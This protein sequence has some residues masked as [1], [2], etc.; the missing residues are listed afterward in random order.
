MGWMKLSDSTPS[1]RYITTT[2][3]STSHSVLDSEA[4]NASA[5]P[6]RRSS[7]PVG[8]PIAARAPSMA[9]TASPSDAPGA[10]LNENVTAG[11]W[12]TWLINRCAGRCSMR[13]MPF[14]GTCLPSGPATCRRAMASGPKA[15]S[16]RASS[17]TRYWLA[18]VKMV[19]IWRWPNA[20]Y[21]ASATA[22]TLMPRRA[23]ATRSIS[24][25]ACRPWSCR[26]LATSARAADCCRWASNRGVHCAS[27]SLSGLVR[28]NWYWVRLIRSSMPSSCTGCRCSVMPGT[29]ATRCCRRAMIACASLLRCAC[30]FS[31]ISN[32]P[33]LSV[34]LLPS[35]PM[36][37]DR[38]AT[39]SS[40]SSAVA[41]ACWRCAMAWNEIDC[42][43]SLMPWIRPASCT[44]KKPLGTHTY[45]AAVSSRVATVA[46]SISGWRCSTQC[47][48][49]SYRATTRS[50]GSPCCADSW[51]SASRRVACPALSRRAHIIGVSVSDTSREIP[52][53]T[54]RVIANS[55]N[56]LPTTSA[57]NSSGISTAISDRV[58]EIRVK[59][60]CRA[61]FSAACIGV[62]PR[63]RWRAMFSS[64]TIASSTTKPVAMVSAIR[65]RLLSENPA[66]SITPKVPTSDSGTAMLGMIVAGR[67]RRNTKV[68]IT[69]S[70]MAISSSCCTPRMEA[71]ID[72]VRSLSTAT[73]TPLGSDA[74]SCGSSARTW[75]TTAIT[76]APGWRWMLISTA[77]V[78]PDHAASWRFSA[79]SS[80][81]ATSPRRSGAPS[82]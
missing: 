4:R 1:T 48:W 17:T 42:G 62:A 76:L 70:A 32:R 82:L 6:C 60:I 71:R 44:G 13:A 37:E 14:N 8:R 45:S 79:P 35:T 24:T 10:R 5:A 50:N 54:A 68:T 77:G 57:M 49:R 63:S 67:L 43:A 9:C 21:S 28:V 7:T 40:S 3:A 38:L 64:I 23:A 59:P 52:I 29:C 55:W 12:P 73:S 51:P 11:N 61:P 58:S 2:A 36:N 65:V 47:S 69:T 66:S 31:S 41:S 16:G 20:S 80:I 18:W 26:S 34:A 78:V 81:V 74:C 33:L 56:S 19:E 27:W 39:S 72:S 15:T 46:P 30:G 75:S 25:C 53:A 22:S